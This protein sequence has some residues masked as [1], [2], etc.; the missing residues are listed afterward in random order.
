MPLQVRPAYASDAP[1]AAAIEVEAYSSNPISNIMFPTGDKTRADSLVSKLNASPACRWT[2]VVDTDIEAANGGNE[3]L[4]AFSMWYFWETPRNDAPPMPVWGPSANDEACRLFYGTLRSNWVK[5][6]AGKPHIYLEYL[7]TDP[8][9]QRRGAASLMLKWG[10]DQADQLGLPIYLEATEAGKPQYEK[11]GFQTIGT[12]AIDFSKW[13]A[14]SNME[15]FLML[16]Q[17]QPVSKEA[18]A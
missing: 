2:K 1:R 12:A 17:P 9:H 18:R 8:K 10:A 13:G 5:H 15:P 11:H 4:V 16:R 6:M 3:A 7:H 14:S